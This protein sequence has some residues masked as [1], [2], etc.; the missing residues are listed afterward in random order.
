MERADVRR[1]LAEEAGDDV[2]LFQVLKGQRATRRKRNAAADN[3]NGRKH[4]GVPVAHVHRPALAAATA[5]GFGKQFGHQ[6]RYRDSACDS[7]RVRPMRAGDH[8]PRFEN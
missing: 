8:V 1:A 7:V 4:A 6:A 2:G 3:S 5:G